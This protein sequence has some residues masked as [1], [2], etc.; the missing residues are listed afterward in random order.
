M[1][2]SY[3]RW[4]APP[5]PPMRFLR[6]SSPRGIRIGHA[7]PPCAPTQPLRNCR[8]ACRGIRPDFLRRKR[9]P[10]RKSR[11][12]PAQASASVRAPLSLTQGIHVQRDLQALFPRPRHRS[13]DREHADLHPRDGHRVE[14]ALGR[15][16]PAGG[17]RRQEGPRGRQGSEGDARPHARQHR[18]R[19]AD[20]GRRHR[21][22]RDHRGDA[23]L[24]HPRGAQPPHAREAAHHHRRSLRH[25][26]GREAR[27]ERG[28]GERRRARGLPDRGA[29]GRGHRRRACP[30]PSRPAT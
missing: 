7:L 16:R 22:L 14:R 6:R 26:R 17:A 12:G 27:G 9:L 4:T 8:A 11:C 18:G 3:F 21:R 2:G 20:E 23:A 5:R 29:D 25:H 30:S 13:R 28:G 10:G 19:P 15:R 24:L 1:H